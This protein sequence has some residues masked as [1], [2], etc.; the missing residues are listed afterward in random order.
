MPI[1]RPAGAGRP[2]TMPPPPL[3]ERR[4]VADAGL[5]M[6][7]LPLRGRAGE[8]SAPG[9]ATF[10]QALDIAARWPPLQTSLATQSAAT[11]LPTAIRAVRQ[12]DP[13]EY[14]SPTQART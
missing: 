12:S 11:V 9:T 5:T 2:G 4:V 1:A 14:D 7:P 10:L 8:R 3:R 6:S 13:R